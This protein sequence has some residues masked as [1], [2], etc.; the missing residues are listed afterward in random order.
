MPGGHADKLD[1]FD[2]FRFGPAAKST[3]S[4]PT[5]VPVPGE[6]R[7]L[8]QARENLDCTSGFVEVEILC[9][10]CRK[11]GGN[12]IQRSLK[13]FLAPV[14]QASR[15]SPSLVGVQ[16]GNISEV[17]EAA[18]ASTTAEPELIK[19]ILYKIAFTK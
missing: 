9:K 16:E 18:A 4:I 12:S 15:A 11:S 7:K 2:S 1:L 19:T 17:V 5:H 3:A 10:Q 6:K 13:N 8:A 14:K